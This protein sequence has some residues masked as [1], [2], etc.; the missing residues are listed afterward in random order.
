ML[1]NNLINIPQI[2]LLRSDKLLNKL[3]DELLN[4]KQVNIKENFNQ[5][6]DGIKDFYPNSYRLDEIELSLRQ[7]E[8]TSSGVSSDFTFKEFD[9]I[10]YHFSFLN[11]I[12]KIFFTFDGSKI[13]TKEENLEEYLRFIT[14]VSP[15]QLIGYK[16]SEELKN[17]KI[18]LNDLFAFI[19][20]YTPLGLRVDKQN[21][22]AENHLH[23][24][25]SSYI[26][27]NLSK[28]FTFSTNKKYFNKKY[29]QELPRINEFSYIN[30]HTYSIGQIV[31]IAKLSIDFIYGSFMDNELN[32]SSKYIENL[33]KIL[34]INKPLKIKYSYS[35]DTISKMSNIFPV[36]KNNIEDNIT[37]EIVKLYN[38]ELFARAHLLEYSLFFYI[39][40]NTKSNYLKI[41][42][43]LY[44]QIANILRSY[45]VMSQ[46]QGLA[47]FSEFS[48]S[49]IRQVEKRNA[50]SIASGIIKGGTSY[51]NAKMDV[52]KQSN[53]ISEVLQD[54]NNAFKKNDNKFNHNYG[55][56]TKKGREKDIRI[57]TGNLHPRF[58][59]KSKEIK[60]EALAL[61]DFIRNIKYK[62][63]DKFSNALKYTKIK[64]YK[65]RSKLKNKTF[66]I[67]SYVVSIDAV[68]KET[69][70]PPE[71]FAPYFKYLRHSAKKLKN[72][73]FLG[74]KSFNHHPKLLITAHAGE[75]FNHIITGMRRVD[76]SVRFFG[77]H[78]R[79]RLGHV[80]S[81]GFFPKDWLNIVNDVLIYQGDYFDDL[82]W[83][84]LRLK[85][86]EN[87]NL[88]IARII[89]IYEDKVW[90]LFAKLYPM[91]K[92]NIQISDLYQAWRYRQ[93]CALTY[94]KQK[95][96]VTQFDDYSRIVLDK[97][98]NKNVQ[99]I[100]ELYQTNKQVRA[101]YKKVLKIDKNDISKEELK[102][103]EAL[104][105]KMINE[106]AVKG[107]IIETNPSSNVFVSAIDSYK[108][109][110]IFRFY[111][112]KQELLKK[113]KKF[114]KFNQRIGRIAVTINSDDPAIFVTTLQ[115]E[116]R[117]IKNVAIQKYKCSDK[118]AEDWIE[119]IRKFGV[120]IFKESYIESN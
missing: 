12:F 32:N 101:N 18:E 99:E 74:T 16:L 77:M 58:Y 76:E 65:N 110:P 36:F 118:E 113:G 71:V 72:D 115:N 75:D 33:N 27:F 59:K 55:L 66:D 7:E 92:K 24:K 80:L 6:F 83:L 9:G 91:S 111:P 4:T 103:W 26:S 3:F 97:K 87:S 119:D 54:F 98:P 61:D 44:L 89:K 13:F 81:L 46:N 20:N 64:A 23:L 63:I 25:G 37:R 40:K 49:D 78:R 1:K 100:Y 79:D 68:G 48:S 11:K 50:N 41:F 53:K 52:K 104:Q 17:K 88:D 35:I 15:L 102:I 8:I 28:L 109:H 10:N 73:I 86:V 38:K 22:Y 51:L 107:I 90:N 82:V 85:K 84:C 34:A 116:Y 62:K 21:K 117:T 93:N 105:D 60:E 5:F 106:L 67:S 120:K 29:L 95:R 2:V 42:I 31:E 19:N 69:H 39:Y 112:P 94:F 56:S 45:M 108:Y 96:G 30:N 47:H 14:K 43:K 70:T 114:N 57:H